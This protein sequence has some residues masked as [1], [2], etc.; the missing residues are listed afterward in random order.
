MDHDRAATAAV[1]RSTASPRLDQIEGAAEALKPSYRASR[2]RGA[3]H[4]P[5][6]WRHG[7]RPHAG[8]RRGGKAGPQTAR[9]PCRRAERWAATPPG[10]EGHG[11]TSRAATSHEMRFPASV[12]DDTSP[13]TFAERS[14]R[15][16]RL[17]TP[18]RWR[19]ATP[20]TL[21]LRRATRSPPPATSNRDDAT[22]DQSSA[23]RPSCRPVGG[24]LRRPRQPGHDVAP[25]VAGSENPDV[26]PLTSLPGRRPWTSPRRAD[27]IGRSDDERACPPLAHLPTAVRRR[28]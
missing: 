22:R 14:A 3:G 7:P 21:A 23:R 4:L 9:P 20:W 28:R 19:R 6:P 12:S 16:P 1:G 24:V 13:A 25:A 10:D 15:A 26:N 18:S 11:G 27:P 8:V 17:R 5:C 2:K